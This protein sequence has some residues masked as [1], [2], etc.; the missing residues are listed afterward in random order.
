VGRICSGSHATGRIGILFKLSR[1]LLEW[2]ASLFV[3]RWDQ[4][5]VQQHDGSYWRVAEPL[6]LSHLAAHLA[7]RWTLGSYVLD[8]S[9]WC[10]FAVFDADGDDGLERLALLSKELLR[11]GVS[12]LLEASRRGGHLWVYLVEP[13]PARL[14]RAWLIPYAV[15]MGVELY[16][17]QDWLSPGG[18]GSLIRFPLGMHQQSRGW[19]PFVECSS[20]GELVPV[21]Q[22]IEECCA[23]VCQH[24]QRVTV[25]AVPGI[26]CAKMFSVQRKPQS[27][28]GGMPGQFAHPYGNRVYRSI[29]EWCLAHDI[30]TAIGRYVTLDHRGV[31]SCP[32]KEHHYRGD[33]RPSFQVFGGEDSHWY[34]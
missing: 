4:Y 16:P 21:G 15:A 13:T 26:S 5:A 12:T 30:M 29:R 24:A 28:E 23:W 18:S 25:P 14:V 33:F 27:A 11:T 31:G 8:A 10:S 7:G 19:Y 3:Q 34:C 6:L 17:K 2:Y 22:T 1:E 32:F 9:S 20:W